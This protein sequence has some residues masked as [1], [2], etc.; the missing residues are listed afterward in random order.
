[1][2]E[3]RTVNRGEAMLAYAAVGTAFGMTFDT[4]QLRLLADLSTS[5]DLTLA[6]TRAMRDVFAYAE[7]PTAKMLA[8]EGIRML[9][10]LGGKAA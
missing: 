4:E 2:S 3:R 7:E 1:M 9:R 5:L 6:A 10:H 8:E